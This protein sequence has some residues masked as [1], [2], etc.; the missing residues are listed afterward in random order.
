MPRFRAANALALLAALAC[1]GAPSAARASSTVGLADSWC[2][3]GQPHLSVTGNAP[4]VHVV[5]AYAADQPDKLAQYGTVIQRYLSAASDQLYASSGGTLSVRWDRG[6]SCGPQ[7]LDIE[8]VQLPHTAA[9]F[10]SATTGADAFR[11]IKADLAGV[12]AR[13]PGDRV[14]VFADGMSGGWGGN[15]DSG[16]DSQPGP[17][18]AANYGTRLAVVYGDLGA[19][20]FFSYASA[21]EPMNGAELALH[22]VFHTLGAVQPDAPHGDPYGHSTEDNELMGMEGFMDQRCESLLPAGFV[23]DC[24]GD[25]Y[26]NV[27]PAPGSYLATHWNVARDSWFLCAPAHC[28]DET[29][30]PDAHLSASTTSVAV[31]QPVSFDASSTWDDGGVARYLF[32]LDGDGK[33]ETDNQGSPALTAPMPAAGVLNVGVRAI[34]AAG[35]YGV[36]T[37]TMNIQPGGTTGNPGTSGPGQ[38]IPRPPTTDGGKPSRFSVSR[39]PSKQAKR[40]VLSHG[41]TIE[42]SAPAAG[43]VKVTV[44]T[45]HRTVGTLKLRVRRSGTFSARVKLTAS[46]R[47]ELR[48][49]RGT[50]RLTLRA[51]LGR[52]ASSRRVTV[53]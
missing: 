38:T 44:K 40:T 27:A 5:Y 50:V 12:L 32:D 2:G 47:A 39:T 4:T 52:A 23:I 17:A 14:L 37:V 21:D 3:D 24:G 35:A 22:E 29:T 25:D 26:F 1:A 46:G 19:P 49:A 6:S 51:T 31:G 9:S 20:G 53:R 34:D 8:A 30:A 41:L 15:A 45:G 42:G 33:F 13:Y 7:Y 11:Q 18:N 16:T 43:T 28:A 48:R 36:S 10:S